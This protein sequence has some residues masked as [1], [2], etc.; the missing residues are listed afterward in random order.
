M[1]ATFLPAEEWSEQEWL[2]CRTFDQFHVPDLSHFHNNYIYVHL[3]VTVVPMISAK[4]KEATT[5][6]TAAAIETI[7]TIDRGVQL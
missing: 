7:T 3:F 4:T 2:S 5:S 1:C 6:D